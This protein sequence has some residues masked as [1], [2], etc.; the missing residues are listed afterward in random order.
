LGGNIGLVSDPTKAKK[1]RD[2][3]KL[4]TTETVFLQKK[5]KKNEKKKNRMNIKRSSLFSDCTE[6]LTARPHR[7]PYERAMEP[8][9]RL[10]SSMAITC[11]V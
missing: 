9:A 2:R 8:E 4:K 10:S 5:E 1:E 3:N 6:T 7:L 11:S